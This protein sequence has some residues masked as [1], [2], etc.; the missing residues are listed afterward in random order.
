MVALALSRSLLDQGTGDA[1]TGEERVATT[2]AM[3]V[4][5]VKGAEAPQSSVG[6]KLQWVPA[7]PGR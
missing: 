2:A 3:Q 6:A 5:E 7:A 1:A 4:M